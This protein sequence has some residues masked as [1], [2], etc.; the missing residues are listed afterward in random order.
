MVKTAITANNESPDGYG[1]ICLTNGVMTAK[2]NTPYKTDGIAANNSTA[3]DII[4]ATFF[5]AM[6]L[7]RLQR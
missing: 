7:V 1:E 2:P 3:G 5:G 6:V 4:F